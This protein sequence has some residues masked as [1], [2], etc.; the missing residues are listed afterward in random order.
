[1][2]ENP[3]KHSEPSKRLAEQVRR[4]AEAN[5]IYYPKKE[6]KYGTPAERDASRKCAL[7]II[8]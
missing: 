3:Y 2:S 4:A 1:M 5:H 6:E 8:G 7:D